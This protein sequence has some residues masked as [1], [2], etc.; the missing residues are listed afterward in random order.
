MILKSY[1]C[2]RTIQI[3]DGRNPTMEIKIQTFQS[4]Q[5]A[6]ITLVN[7]ERN[8]WLNKDSINIQHTL[9]TTVKPLITN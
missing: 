2:L 3:E 9:K 5:M 1:K 7:R 8:I 6:S 4:F